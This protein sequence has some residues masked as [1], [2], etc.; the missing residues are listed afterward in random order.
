MS[1]PAGRLHVDIGAEVSTAERNVARFTAAL[2]A[3]AQSAQ[4][5]VAVLDRST[6]AH[7]K[8]TASTT[9]NQ[10]ATLALASAE[11]RLQVAQGNRTQ[12]AATLSNAIARATDRTTQLVNAERQLLQIQN[13]T[14]NSAAVL[15]RT[16]AGLSHEALRTAQTFLGFSTALGGLSVVLGKAKE[17][18]ELRAALDET[19]RNAGALFENVQRGNQVFKEAIAFG[20]QFGFTQREAANAVQGL[21]IVMK[22]S[23][24]STQK[25]LE[26]TARLLTLNREEDFGG[27]ARAISELQ[28]GQVTSIVQRFNLSRNAANALKKEIAGGKDAFLALDAVLTKMGVT[29]DILAQ[30]TQGAAGAQRTFAQATEDL[31]LALGRLA[32]GPGKK[33]LEVLTFIA[34]NTA[35]YLN[36][37]EGQRQIAVRTVEVSRSYEEYGQKLAFVNEQLAK[38]GGHQAPLTTFQFNYAKGLMQTGTAAEDAYMKAEKMGTVL[39]RAAQVQGRFW[40]TADIGAASAQTLREKM[41]QLA[42]TSDSN[43]AIIEGLSAGFLNGTVSATQLQ[44]A[45]GQLTAREEALANVSNIQKQV[46]EGVNQVRQ[47]GLDVI[48]KEA[49]ETLTAEAA[50]QKL[51]AAKNQIYEAAMAAARGM[52]TT[53]HAAARLAAQFPGATTEAY[54]LITALRELDLV[55]A[56]GAAAAIGGRGSGAA[57]TAKAYVTDATNAQKAYQYSVATTAGKLALKRAELNKTVK[58]SAEYYNV[59]SDIR[60]LENQLAAERE[61]NA[62][63]GAT[64]QQKQLDLT[65]RTTDALRKQQQAVVSAELGVID[66]ERKRM[67]EARRV[68]Q[69]QKVLSNPNASAEQRAAAALVLREVPLLQRQRALEIEEKQSTANASLVNGRVY[70]SIPGSGNQTAPVNAGVP[71]SAASAAIAPPPMAVPASAASGIGPVTVNLG[72]GVYLNSRQIAAELQ[73]QHNDGV[74]V[75]MTDALKSALSGGI[76]EG[77]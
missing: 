23:T 61:R 37:A 40:E 21:A 34:N 1:E 64:T 2:K 36:A 8:S 41:I 47:V 74:I 52:G 31:N 9:Q 42:A 6:A 45:V 19:R 35:T 22:N 26:V 20:R 44:T 48:S 28:A 75:H 18:F 10:R 54:G 32:E 60:Q 33:I 17:G 51:A 65:E 71:S 59:L 53:E 38:L 63:H 24:S 14:N 15:P 12:G 70:Q 72:I 5:S 58:G 43:R 56:T 4:N 46:Q 55:T 3:A 66:D 39:T 49:T 30:R 69:A 29:A 76:S 73:V 16:L 27:A 77:R 13:Q 7:N 68:R 62:K 11:A 50:S 67:E 25:Q 57:A